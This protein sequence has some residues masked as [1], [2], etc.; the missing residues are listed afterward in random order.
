[1]R[2]VW[3]TGHEARVRRSPP[4][5]PGWAHGDVERVARARGRV[6]GLQ[7]RAADAF[8]LVLRQNQHLRHAQ[9]RAVRVRVEA[10]H[11]A[12]AGLRARA[13]PARLPL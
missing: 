12:E 3:A 2:V 9:A 7:Q 11:R 6:R 5:R 8:A 10:V 4:A 13:A 1:M